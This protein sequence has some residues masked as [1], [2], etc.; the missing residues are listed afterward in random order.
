MSSFL[1]PLS[2]LDLSLKIVVIFCVSFIFSCFFSLGMKRLLIFFSNIQTG[3]KKAKDQRIKTI[4]M[5]IRSTGYFLIGIT[6][7]VMILKEFSLDTSPILAS[8]GI[9]GLAGSL[10]AQTL[11]KDVIAGLFILIENQ[12]GVG[13]EIQ[14]DEK[15]GIV[16]KLTLRRAIL[17]DT[18]GTIHHVPHGGVRIVSVLKSQEKG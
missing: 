16:Q 4:G 17:Q 7:V 10:G 6:T 5:V 12:Y 15:Q 3:S 13:D 18:N 9:I 1:S 2:L 11:I 14:L 8:V